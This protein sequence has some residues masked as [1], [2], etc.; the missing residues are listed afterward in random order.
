MKE[1]ASAEAVR[2][3]E[4]NLLRVEL[5]KC[6]IAENRAI[7]KNED[8][9]D[10]RKQR[11]EI[12]ARI[13]EKAKLWEAFDKDHAFREASLNK[14][15]T[16]KGSD[17]AINQLM[18]TAF[19]RAWVIHITVESPY[20]FTIKWIDGSEMVVGQLKGGLYDDTK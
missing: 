15:K 16:L 5:E 14:L 19:I 20:L 18:D 4:Q 13:N 11:M 6:L 1:L 2:E 3:R 9:E 12:E 10:I 17:K 7:I 8:T